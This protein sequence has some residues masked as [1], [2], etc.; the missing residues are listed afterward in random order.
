MLR[1]GN[2]RTRHGSRCWVQRAASAPPI[3]L[4]DIGLR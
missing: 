2:L 3:S 1:G 4:A